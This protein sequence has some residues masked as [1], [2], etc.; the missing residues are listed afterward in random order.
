MGRAASRECN[1]T[2]LLKKATVR[3]EEQ[4]W[5]VAGWKLFLFGESLGFAVG[6]W[7]WVFAATFS[8]I[9]DG[10]FEN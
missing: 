5:I 8:C 3:F 7:Y 9:S 10:L 2:R 6:F 1:Y 4:G